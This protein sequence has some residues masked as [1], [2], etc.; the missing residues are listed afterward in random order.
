MPCLGRPCVLTAASGLR[1]YWNLRVRGQHTYAALPPAPLSSPSPLP[2]HL[3]ICAVEQKHH[4]LPHNSHPLLALHP[5]PPPRLTVAAAAPPVVTAT[6]AASSRRS[7]QLFPLVLDACRC[8]NDLVDSTL[9]PPLRVLT[10]TRPASFAERGRAATCSGVG[11]CEL[12]HG[13]CKRR[14]AFRLAD[15]LPRP[16][17]RLKCN[18]T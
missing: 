17:Q 3:R 2:A 5:P 1:H 6:C 11:R 13:H 7:E 10:V 18:M 14:S 12:L 15:P 9:H 8:K 4:P 16:M